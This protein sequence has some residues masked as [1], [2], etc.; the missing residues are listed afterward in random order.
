[1]PQGKTKTPTSSSRRGPLTWTVSG[2]GLLVIL[3]AIFVVA[4]DLGDSSTAPDLRVTETGR[5][6]N[7]GMTQVGIEIRNLGGAAAA[8]VQVEGTS[9]SGDTGQVSL[10]YVAGR[11]SREATLSFPG[12]P[13]QVE[14][15][16]TGWTK[17]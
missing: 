5:V 8:A 14:V 7:A 6:T 17:P 2:V 13:G 16:V 9:A 10:D 15:S 12:N 1:M 3:V 4:A 11:S